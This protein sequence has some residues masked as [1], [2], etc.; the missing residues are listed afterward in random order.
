MKL[1][2]INEAKAMSGPTVFFVVGSSNQDD[3]GRFGSDSKQVEFTAG[4]FGNEN[5]AKQWIKAVKQQFKKAHSLIWAEEHGWDIEP[6]END[7]YGTYNY[8]DM[9]II[10]AEDPRKLLSDITNAAQEY[11][12]LNPDDY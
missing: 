10:T 2:Q 7:D 1:T 12:Q 4:P 6:Y 3:T 9:E 5:Q 8:F 11:S